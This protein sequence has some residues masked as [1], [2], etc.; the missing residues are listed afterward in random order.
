MLHSVLQPFR[1]TRLELPVILPN[2][3]HKY[4]KPA[5]QPKWQHKNPWPVVK[6]LG[7]PNK[8]PIDQVCLPLQAMTGPISTRY[9]RGHYP[10]IFQRQPLPNPGT[11]LAAP[12][13]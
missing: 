13:T 7:W 2:A 10:H 8:S 9:Q 5:H 1:T 3:G 11:N 12:M 6:E 4:A